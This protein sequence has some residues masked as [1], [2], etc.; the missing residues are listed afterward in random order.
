MDRERFMLVVFLAAM[1]AVMTGMGLSQQPQLG[2]QV[3]TEHGKVDFSWICLSFAMAFFFFVGVRM[4]SIGCDMG[5][6]IAM[7]NDIRLENLRHPLLFWQSNYYPMWHLL[8]KL[9]EAVFHMNGVLAAGMVNGLCYNACLIGIYA[10]LRKSF[11]TVDPC[12]LVGLAFAVC[13]VGCML[14]PWLDIPHLYENT[15]NKWHNP[16]NAMVKAL[17]LPCVLLTARLL[18]GLPGRGGRR[19]GTLPTDA[20]LDCRF[21]PTWPQVMAL[22]VLLTLTELAKPS[23][24]QVYLPTMFLFCF[25]CFWV[26]RKSIV[27]S[28]A[29]SLSW[30]LPCLVL[31]SQYILAFDS[32]G[33]GG[34]GF[35]FMAI[36]G[37]YDHAGLNQFYAVAF[38]VVS[39]IAAI[40]RRRVHI[41]DI[42]CWLMLSIGMIMRLFLF[43]LGPRMLHGNLGWGYSVA[44]YLVWVIGIRQY[45]DL[46]VSQN[47]IRCRTAFWALSVLLFLHVL[48]GFYKMYDMMCLGSSC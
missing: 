27:P 4:A 38:P 13:T 47:G 20:T 41:E 15:Q 31:L 40:L 26:N 39:L 24:I 33:S 37:R 30:L 16:T 42:L 1:A 18:E 12:G 2:P 9:F 19:T 22:G 10:Y 36:V 32:E 35:G 3:P 45:V 8:V 6:H 23:F 7:A 46:A 5:D 43:E 11:R 25:G 28:L 14:G 21:R 48:T 44:L 34:I 29:L 17:A